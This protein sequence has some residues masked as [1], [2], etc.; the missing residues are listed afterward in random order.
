MNVHICWEGNLRKLLR[1]MSG[2]IN[3]TVC[4]VV[5]SWLR[6]G[7]YYMDNELSGSDFVWIGKD[8]PRRRKGGGIGFLVRREC[9]AKVAKISAS[10]SIL[11]IVMDWGAGAKL[12]CA[13]V[14]LVPKDPE[15]SNDVAIKELQQDVL[16]FRKLG[17]TI[18]IGDFNARVGNYQTLLQI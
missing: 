2:N 11:W 12:F 16:T 8:R 15:D 5:E 1:I 10:E 4:G 9:K 13:V 17:R 14:Y 18:V 3:L 7:R 6:E